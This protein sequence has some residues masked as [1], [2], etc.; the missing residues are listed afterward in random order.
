MEIPLFHEK[1]LFHFNLSRAYFEGFFESCAP[2]VVPAGAFGE[3]E[4]CLF[5]FFKSFVRLSC[6]QGPLGSCKFDFSVFQALRPVAV[7]AGAFREL[8]IWLF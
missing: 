2:D 5:Q 3:L 4:I 8:E 6:P 7:P 1:A